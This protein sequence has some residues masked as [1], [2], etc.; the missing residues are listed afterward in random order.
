MVEAS[1]NKIVVIQKIPQKIRANK[2]K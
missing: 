1:E 2:E